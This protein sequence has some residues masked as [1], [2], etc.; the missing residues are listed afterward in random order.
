[1]SENFL[2]Q[3]KQKLDEWETM[4]SD[5]EEQAKT[6]GTFDKLELLARAERLRTKSREIEQKLDLLEEVESDDRKAEIRDEVNAA[7]DEIASML[8][9]A[10][11]EKQKRTGNN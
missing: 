5:I 3:A 4:I 11:K 8:D 7:Q 10:E 6:V 1:M 2:G 9:E